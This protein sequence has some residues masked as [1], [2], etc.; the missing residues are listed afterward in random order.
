MPERVGQSPGPIGEKK[1]DGI[2][3]RYG[4]VVGASIYELGGPEATLAYC[5]KDAQLVGAALGARGYIVRAMHDEA[6]S[7]TLLPTR[8]NVLRVLRAMVR[9]ADED[10]L[11]FVHF[12]CHG[13]L[14]GSRPYLVLRDTPLD[15]QKL[16]KEGLAL[17]TVLEILRAGHTRWV[18]IFLDACHI[19]LGIDPD[20]VL[21]AQEIERR[22]G[23]F[24][25]LSGST[26]FQQT[27]DSDLLGGG[28]FSRALADGLSGAAAEADGSVSFSALAQH[29]QN[30]VAEWKRSEEGRSKLAKQRPVL[31]MELADLPIV[32]PLGYLELSPGHTGPL[33]HPEM[34]QKI[35]SACFSPDGRWL[36]TSGEDCT[37]RLWR[38]TTGEPGPGPM[39]HRGHVGGVAF[40]PDALHLL[41]ASNDGTTR[42]W[43]AS[44]ASEI[45]PAPEA[46]QA[47]VH[48]VAYSP[49]GLYFATASDLGAHL[50]IK[51][52]PSLPVHTWQAHE[53]SVWAIAFSPDGKKLVSGGQDGFARVWDLNTREALSTLQMDGPVWALT[54]SKDG[55]SV[56]SAGA[57][58]HSQSRLVNLPRVW[59]WAN[60]RVRFKL[61][62]HTRAVT[63]VSCSPD[64]RLF[65]TASY[66]GSARIWNAETGAQLAL[67]GAGNVAEAYGAVFSPDGRLLFVGY[68]DGRGLLYDVLLK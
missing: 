14:M 67:Y 61:V 22:A 1:G 8:R 68:A 43:Q 12:S 39:W 5:T 33:S 17:A 4:L 60:E 41:S 40:S 46:M 59:D 7:P 24:A 23:G 18:A 48:A 56:L 53:G 57:D 26:S 6:K 47:R 15:D 3:R 35:R 49:D 55:K 50:Y 20:A 37:V 36:A 38:P 25:L 10:D 44:G 9:I 28:V 52:R 29:V 54:F 19:G 66:D 62:G 27:Q 2:V 31:R 42:L 30:K 45:S 16:A 13:K 32:P 11:L 65:A 21:S 34:S 64:G 51:H 63:A 58:L